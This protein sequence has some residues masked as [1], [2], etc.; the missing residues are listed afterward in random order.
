MLPFLSL[1]RSA[2]TSGFSFHTSPVRIGTYCLSR[3][4]GTQSR[5]WAS[6]SPIF[7]RS[8][9]LSTFHLQHLLRLSAASPHTPDPPAPGLQLTH[10][11]ARSLGLSQGLQSQ[12]LHPAARRASQI[13]LQ[14]APLSSSAVLAIDI[15]NT[16]P[17][18]DNLSP[19]HQTC[20]RLPGPPNLL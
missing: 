11:D 12:S 9:L 17:H 3:Q 19:L 14:Q 8:T 18:M 1:L 13:T 6:S 10:E 16:V 5:A 4:T 15:V 2:Q 7:R 20:P